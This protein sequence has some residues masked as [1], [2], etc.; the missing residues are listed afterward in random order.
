MAKMVALNIDWD[1][2]MD[3]AFEKVDGTAV[4]NISLIFNISVEKYNSLSINEKHDLVLDKFR[5]CP[6]LLYD[7]MELL[8]FLV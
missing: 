7:F 5:H 6:G 2:D 1:I 3:E 8:F 4:E